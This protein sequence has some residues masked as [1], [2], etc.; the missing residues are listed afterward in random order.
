MSVLPFGSR[1]PAGQ[2]WPAVALCLLAADMPALCARAPATRLAAGG[3]ALLPV[4]VSEKASD[5][6][7]KVA[8]EL[9]GYLQRISGA[10]FVVAAGD[11]KRGI[12]LGTLE[13]FPHPELA[14]ALEIRNTYDG[15]EAYAIR[16]QPG[17]VLLIGATELGASHA[18]FRFLEALGC[19]W[20]FP[21][22]EWEVV[23][24]KPALSAAVNETSRPALLARRIWYGWGLGDRGKATAYNDAWARHNR[25]AASLKTNCGHAWQSII[26]DNRAA[27]Q[28]HPEYLALVKGKRQGEQLC[29]SNPAVRKLACEWAVAQLKRHPDADMVSME[30]SDGN[31]QCECDECRKLGSISDRVFGLANEVA[32][33]VA[34][35]CPGKMVGLYAYNEHCEPPSFPLE[36]NVYVQSTHGFIRGR[37]TFEELM[38]LWP[39]RCRNMG[40]YEYYSVFQW[41]HDMPLGGAGGNVPYLRKQ[42]PLYVQRAAT[43]V[44]CESGCNWGLHGR[45]YYV[46]NKLMWNP[47]TDVDALLADFYEKAFGPAAAVMKRYYERLDP[48]NEPLLSEDLLARAL[49]DLDEAARLAK[50]RPDIIARLDDLK[51]YQHYVRLRWEFDREKDKARRKELALA[52]LTHVYRTRENYMNHWEAVRQNETAAFAKQFDEP[53]WSFQD[54]TPAKAWKVDA[55][56]SHEETERLFQ[57]DLKYFTPQPVT[58]KSFSKVLVPAGFH[59]ENP[60]ESR[61]SYQGG[62]VYALY[63][64]AGEPLEMAITTGVIAWYRDR[65]DA[66][67][68]ITDA[69]EKVIAT[70]HLPQDGQEHALSIK[71]PAAGLY[72]LRFDDRGAAWGLKVAAGRPVSLA[73]QRGS[74]PAHLGHMQRMYF[75][76]PKGT[77]ELCYYFS[78][79]SPHDVYGPDGKLAA[80]VEGTGKFVTLPVPAGADGKAWSFGRLCIGRLWFFNAPNVLAGSPDALLLPKEVVGE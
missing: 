51:Q 52:I 4:V 24:S 11:G 45:G 57:E 42:I 2:L 14:K 37:Y 36:P 10:E 75:Y 5:G 17:R 35:E 69:K 41:D 27:F 15:R 73:L 3:K 6:T 26:A 50:D 72:W 59:T 1:W 70:D 44:D 68:T 9:A 7:K 38:D 43:S 78:G 46:A 31:G 21:P 64:R 39:K 40:F 48:G 60:A 47:K 19:R 33:A 63:S 32:R 12:V 23:P 71:V 54:P 34:K 13:E 62:A 77:R 25:M 66:R 55:P 58:E 76:V 80:T 67:Y 65:P 29:V 49:R 22:P 79:S 30:C 18:A 16:C 74:G 56:P 61:Q 8:A 53:A 20:F 28:E